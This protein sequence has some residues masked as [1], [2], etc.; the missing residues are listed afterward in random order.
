MVPSGPGVRSPDVLKA[1]VDSA[2]DGLVVVDAD[3]LIVL[4]N[5][6]AERM[7]GYAR[8]ELLGQAVEALVPAQ[9][10]HR[11][12]AD[13]RSFVRHPRAR[14]MGAGLELHGRRRDGTEFPVEI[15]LSPIQTSDG[16]LVASAIR[17]ISY[18]RRLELERAHLA[19]IVESS[20][21]AILSKTLDGRI[22]SWNR[23]AEAIFGYTAAEAM[24]RPVGMLLPP[25]S[26]EEE[27]RILEQVRSGRSVSAREALRRRK[28]GRMI[29]VSLSVSP[30]RDRSGRVVAA[31]TIVRDM[32][33]QK[34]SEAK[35]QQLLESAPD[36]MVIAARDGRIVLVNAQAERVF[37]HTRDEMLGQPVEMLVPERFR[38]RHPAHRAGFFADP[39][40]RAMGTGRQLYGLRKDGSE[41]P[42]EISLSPIETE[43]GLLVSSAIRDVTG[44]LKAERVQALNVELEER[45][46]VRT[47]ELQA[48]VQ[49]LEAF[50]YSVSHDLRAP[51]RA[52]H[53]FSQILL[54][55]HA[56]TLSEDGRHCVRRIMDAARD[57][58][59]LVD[60]LL[61][62]SR[63]GRQMPAKASVDME[64]LVAE[65][66]SGLEPMK[67]GRR[68]AVQIDDLPRASA[69][70]SLMR[71][72]WTN[73]LNNA[74]KYTRHADPAR[75]RVGFR[76]GAYYVQDN[77]VGFDMKHAG[78]L[79][80]VFQRL[81]RAEDYEGTGVGLAI[82]NRIVTRHGG[83]I[84]ADATP[85]EGAT[86]AFTLEEA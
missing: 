40:V 84:W 68:V 58:G 66:L 56:Q 8:K 32:S 72:V 3:G 30:V 67:T 50:T 78:G 43:E 36:A 4:V 10:R 31:A 22:Q 14:A 33:Q 11:H 2:P 53:G 80:G 12:A 54:E 47:E 57:M 16:M 42:V 27:A 46:E 39:R 29:P 73:L 55:E 37:G 76:D 82:A 51:L 6:Q 81:H 49:E 28:D 18:R 25:G 15:S 85:G 26:E 13:R 60:D 44:R 1:L 71:Q 48:A 83:R 24:G 70:V 86:F 65:V 21:D 63:L 52:L 38:G 69:D 7:F 23:A 20:G 5:K 41:F 45:V 77:G 62:F 75:I 9:I 74:L 61:T 34:R 79:F 17:D 59:Q 19:S 64:G 35:F